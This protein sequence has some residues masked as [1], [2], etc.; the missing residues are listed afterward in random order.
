MDME[1]CKNCN[2][3]IFCYINKKNNKSTYVCG[4][5]ADPFK[6]IKNIYH[7]E[8]INWTDIETY[9]SNKKCNGFKDFVKNKLS[10]RAL[11]HFNKLMPNKGC[12]YY[13]EQ[14]LTTLN[15]EVKE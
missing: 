6:N 14:Y 8:N 5:D 9:P 10:K 15:K 12:K 13:T 11:S 2:V 3:L 4:H 7:K 1:I